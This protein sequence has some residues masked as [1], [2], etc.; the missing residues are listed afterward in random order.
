M[1]D[2]LTLHNLAL[3]DAACR[4]T[5][6]MAP[7]FEPAA[8]LAG[9]VPTVLASDKAGNFHAA[10][11]D[12]Y[13]AK[14]FMQPPTFHVWDIHAGRTDRNNGPDVA[15]QQGAAGVRDVRRGHQDHADL[16][17][18][19]DGIHHNF[20]RPRTGLG[21]GGDGHDGLTPA[22]AARIFVQGQNVWMTLVQNAR[23]HQRRRGRLG[24]RGGGSA[25]SAA[26]VAG[27]A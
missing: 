5:S 19:R 2:S 7:L 24:T 10:W 4:G 17:V 22:R 25:A 15:V 12:P 3:Q 18:P 23:L 27:Q 11:K 16:A 20:V 13:R 8:G 9:F 26:S 14:N 21:S 6:D 1:L